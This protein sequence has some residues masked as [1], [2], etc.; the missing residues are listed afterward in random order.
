MATL[1]HKL[2]SEEEAIS[3]QIVV[4]SQQFSNPECEI[5]ALQVGKTEGI[6]KSMT[7]HKGCVLTAGICTLE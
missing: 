5:N 7:G 6:D 1:N 4:Y 3:Q 2:S